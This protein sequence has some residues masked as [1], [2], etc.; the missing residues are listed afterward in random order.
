M[1]DKP[2]LYPKESKPEKALRTVKSFVDIFCSV[3]IVGPAIGASL[4]RVL[5]SMQQQRLDEFVEQV[6][7]TLS[8]MPEAIYSSEEFADA[9]KESM[10]KCIN[11][12]SKKKRALFHSI[13]K[14]YLHCVER[15]A[16]SQYD[17]FIRIA[18]SLSEN[19]FLLLVEINTLLRQKRLHRR[20]QVNIHISKR[21]GWNEGYQTRYFSELVAQGLVLE[22]HSG[23]LVQADDDNFIELPADSD[24]YVTV[25]DV[26]KDFLAWVQ[27]EHM[28]P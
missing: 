28:K 2:I 1:R 19:S 11:Q 23:D 14:S 20:G 13:Y 3:P 9:T 6:S 21:Y 24:K 16:Y 17:M 8:S 4:E 18:D 12:N 15:A 27:H 7:D 25:T 26:G 22:E 10:A 5:S